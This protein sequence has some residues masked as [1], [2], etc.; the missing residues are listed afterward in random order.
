MSACAAFQ[1]PFKAFAARADT[2]TAW[3][4]NTGN[5][6]LIS[7][8]AAGGG[9]DFIARAI[10]EEVRKL[11]D[12]TAYVENK[13]GA[14][15]TIANNLLL[16]AAADGKTN[17]IGSVDTQ[18]ISPLIRGEIEKYTPIVPVLG[19]AEAPYLLAAPRAKDLTLEAVLK[20]GQKSELNIATAGEGTVTSVLAKLFEKHVGGRINIIPYNGSGPAGM[21]LLSSVV[22]VAW[23]NTA[24]AKAQQDH[25]HLLATASPTTLEDFPSVPTLSSLGIDVQ[26]SS[27][28]GWF[29]PPGL[30]METSAQLADVLMKAKESAAFENTVKTAGMKALRQ[31][32]RDFQDFCKHEIA[33]WRTALV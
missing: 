17:L 28:I 31:N 21:A 5:I 8:F 1:L 4:G 22:D 26:G 27:W 30:P 11:T 16:N 15:G 29:C 23:V 25:L 2:P 13:P 32:Q 7:P 9:T 24:F 10:A 19:L 6:R 18:I 33:R 20:R 14:S 12:V 3:S